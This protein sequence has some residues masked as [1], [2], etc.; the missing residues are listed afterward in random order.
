MEEAGIIQKVTEPTPWVSSM[1]VVSKKDKDQ[2]R[3]CIDPTDLNKAI[4]R[5]HH[6]MN[7]IDD[8]ATRLRGSKWFSTLD[9]NMGYF[10]MKLTERSSWLTTYNTPFGRYSYLRMPM[11][12]KCSAEVFQRAIASAFQDIEGTEVVVDDIL[13]HGRTLEEHNQRLRQVL[14]RCRKI[15]LRLNQKKCRIQK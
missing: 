11:G 3:I 2:V 7:H 13:V 9:A 6:P 1:V 4:L 12:D 5:E 8:I 14:E 10:Q 15:N